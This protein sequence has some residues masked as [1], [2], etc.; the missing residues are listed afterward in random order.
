MAVGCFTVVGCSSADDSTGPGVKKTGGQPVVLDKNASRAPRE[1]SDVAIV[2]QGKVSFP[3]NSTTKE[4]VSELKV[5]TVIAGNR[6]TVNELSGSK[7]PYGFL[8]KVKSIKEGNPIVIETEQAYLPDLLEGD[9]HFGDDA[10]SSIFTDAGSI[11]T[12]GLRTLA[13]G[14][15]GST[16][17]GTASLL[18]EITND[19]SVKVKFSE[20]SFALD[21][22]FEGDLKIRKWWYIPTG[23][24]HALAK[25]TLDPKAT[26]DISLLASVELGSENLSKTWEGPSLPI[27]LGG[28]IPVTLRLRPE[29]T[30]TA[31]VTGEID[32]TGRAFMTGHT[33]A[34]FEYDGDL[35]SVSEAPQLSAGYE[36][37]RVTGTA[38]LTGSCTIQAVVSVLAFDAVGIE[39]KLG[40]FVSLNAAVC[41]SVG[42]GGAT[43]GFTLYE[44]HGLQADIDGRLQVPGL[45]T[46][47]YNHNVFS[48]NP[49]ESDPH[50]FVGN[51]KTCTAPGIDSCQGRPNGLYCSEV[52]ENSAFECKDNQIAGGQQCPTGK[53]CAGPLTNNT[54]KCE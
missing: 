47:S 21:A 37:K 34:G 5:G 9:L 44:Q 31:T 30:C 13:N 8:R 52:T 36:F 54:I 14:N 23:I 41:G 38:T 17:S 32:I 26:V 19:K 6:D 27:P 46:P 18:G 24:E 22:K 48:F 43:G 49:V 28:P 42:T 53:K 10:D 1:V 39:G 15:G 33:A 3:S 12:K 16:G 45:G 40:P 2:E 29:I 51:D 50:Y 4:W 20:G 7:N 25:L 11:K 35:K